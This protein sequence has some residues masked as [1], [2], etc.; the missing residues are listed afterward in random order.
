MCLFHR[1]MWF[2]SYLGP[3]G[4]WKWSKLSVQ[5]SSTPCVTD[6][7]EIRECAGRWDQLPL[8]KEAK[9]INLI[10]KLSNQI[11]AEHTL[12]AGA[13]YQKFVIWKKNQ[14]N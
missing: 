6:C 3:F 10:K 12:I 13:W 7:S 5:T 2:F 11:I 4:N 9:R 8:E 14:T 1:V